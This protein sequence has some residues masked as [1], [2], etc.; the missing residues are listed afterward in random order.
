MTGTN[1]TGTYYPTERQQPR[2]PRPWCD[3]CG[4]DQHLLAESVT[5]M[6]NSVG[7]LAVAFSCS[8][9]R[10]SRVLATTVELLAPILARYLGPDEDVVHLGALYIH[11]GEPMTPSDAGRRELDLPLHTQPGPA[12]FLGAYLQT[13]VLHCR[14]GFQTEPFH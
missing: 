3:T 7:S 2:G 1:A 12:D 13:R 8:V 9:C 14:C 11:C 6:D 5:V 4:T 10:G